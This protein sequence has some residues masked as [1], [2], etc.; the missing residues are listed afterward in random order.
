MPQKEVTWG[1]LKIIDK[2]ANK[3][4]KSQVLWLFNILSFLKMYS[5]LNNFL[6]Y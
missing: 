4:V 2:H 1:N 5:L 6:F 3:D